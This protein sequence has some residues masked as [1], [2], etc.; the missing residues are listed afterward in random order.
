MP[1]FEKGVR[2]EVYDDAFPELLRRTEFRDDLL[3]IADEFVVPGAQVRAPH[4]TGFGAASIHSEAELDPDGW[5]AMVSWSRDA[6]Y[7][8]FHEF[9]TR[10]MDADPFLRPAAEELQ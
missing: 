2:V 9:G 6:Y 10:Y 8:S 5:V 1:T 4:R 7:M 3:D